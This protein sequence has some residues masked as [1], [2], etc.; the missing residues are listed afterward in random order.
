MTSGL[1]SLVV[2]VISIAA[3]FAA[4]REPK[5]L[6]E[7]KGDHNSPITDPV[8]FL[9]GIAKFLDQHPSIFLRKHYIDNQE[10]ELA[11]AGQFQASCAIRIPSRSTTSAAR[12]KV[13]R[14]TSWSIW[15]A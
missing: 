3:N 2:Q 1:W 4:A 11:A 13:S 14:T 6:W 7:I 12:A 10:I 8:T 5:L 15:M 9:A